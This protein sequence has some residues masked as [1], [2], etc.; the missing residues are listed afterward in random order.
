MCT[1]EYLIVLSEYRV[2]LR[3][4]PV[5]IYKRRRSSPKNR[6][7]RS[8]FFGELRRRAADTGTRRNNRT[9]RKT[10]NRDPKKYRRTF[11]EEETERSSRGGLQKQTARKA[12]FTATGARRAR[13]RAEPIAARIPPRGSDFLSAFQFAFG[14][15]AI[16]SLLTCP[17]YSPSSQQPKESARINFLPSSP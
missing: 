1:I 15:F 2:G 7:L 3:R 13:H 5:Y 14:I 10:Q 9:D 16:V 11:W 8:R 17:M 6:S 4:V 12:Q